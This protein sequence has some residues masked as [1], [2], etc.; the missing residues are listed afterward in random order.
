MLTAHR[1][2]AQAALTT[3]IDRVIKTVRDVDFR[4]R[5]DLWITCR[6]HLRWPGRGRHPVGGRS[7]PAVEGRG[8]ERAG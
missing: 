2:E 8:V 7:R 5:R 4:S 6:T 3:E 1:H